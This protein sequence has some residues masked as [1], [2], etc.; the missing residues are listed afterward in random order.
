MSRVT[1]SESLEIGNRF[2][3]EYKRYQRTST[4]EGNASDVAQL[5]NSTSSKLL[6]STSFKAVVDIMLN[7]QSSNLL[8]ERY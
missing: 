7:G 4:F 3:G 2:T 5:I 6:P 8:N 1:V